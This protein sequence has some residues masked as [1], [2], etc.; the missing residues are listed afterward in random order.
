MTMQTDARMPGAARG[1]ADPVQDAQRVFRTVLTALSRPTLAQPFE[2]ATQPPAPLDAATG[3]VLLALCDEQTPIWLD[4]ALRASPEVGAWLRFHTGARL[5]DAPATHSS[6]SR[7][8][9][10]PSRRWTC[11]PQARMRSRTA[12][13]R[14]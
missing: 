8:H 13:R 1:F 2:P 14:S 11:S 12:P 10:L 9:L 4:S 7:R 6:S 3:A 5:V